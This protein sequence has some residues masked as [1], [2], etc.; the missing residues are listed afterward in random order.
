MEGKAVVVCIAAFSLHKEH[1]STPTNHLF[2]CSFASKSLLSYVSKPA[3]GNQ[4][5]ASEGQLDGGI[6]TGF[7]VMWSQ[8]LIDSNH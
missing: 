6:G 1:I 8:W 2:G 5:L 7:L 3:S 4:L